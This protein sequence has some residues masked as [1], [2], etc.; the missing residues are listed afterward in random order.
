MESLRR[1][2]SK[3]AAGALILG[4]VGCESPQDPILEELYVQFSLDG[5]AI[6]LRAGPE[7]SAEQ[8]SG[9]TVTVLGTPCAYEQD[10]SIVIEASLSI[11]AYSQS[12]ISG[13]GKLYLEIP[14]LSIGS[15]TLNSTSAGNVVWDWP[16]MI[17]SGETWH[18][19]L[20]LTS[21]GPPG[22][23]AEGSF[24]GAL[25]TDGTDTYAV[26]DG[27][28]RVRVYPELAPGS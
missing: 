21:F 27:V 11:Y 22:G 24:S 16:N 23:T 6:D 14:G 5:T 15:Y 17:V 12:F 4:I 26:T 10:G 20:E 7:G 19:D 2:I 1:F 28:F 13:E 9:G 18:I 8:S 3:V 25:T